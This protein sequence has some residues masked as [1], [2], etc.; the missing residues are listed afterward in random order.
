LSALDRSTRASASA[1][2]E[3]AYHRAVGGAAFFLA[4][5]RKAY[6]PCELAT[7]IWRERCRGAAWEIATVDAFAVT[8]LVHL[9]ELGLLRD[10]LGAV[11]ADADARG[12]VYTATSLRMGWP[13]FH[14]LA[15]DRPDE[16]RALA[17]E[18]IRAWPRD[19]FLVQHYLHLVA[20]VHCDLY[21]GD[22]WRAWRTL[23]EAWP[24]LKA[25]YILTVAVTRVDLLN[26]RARVALAAAAAD[27]GSL[28]DGALGPDP[29][30]PRARLRRH[31]RADAVRIRRHSLP[32][33]AP[34][35]DAIEAAL[36]EDASTAASLFRRAAVGFADA[37]MRM[38]AAFAT[39]TASSVD[40]GPTGEGA[41]MQDIRS[42]DA[43]KRAVL[44]SRV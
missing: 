6:D 33:A 9:G 3:G 4:Q 22:V 36:A 14:W 37:G 34:F 17:D 31:A 21:T 10:R 40:G 43:T 24:K 1:F 2:D 30:W 23:C 7:N 41:G 16:A 20:T 35:A 15:E 29:A 8:A 32:T 44:P 42:A 39:T 5:W 28:P 26:L 18:A 12:D 19:R 11:L 13:N 38:H 27:P 25:A